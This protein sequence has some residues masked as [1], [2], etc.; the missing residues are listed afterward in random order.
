MPPSTPANRPVAGRQRRVFA[1]VACAPP[2]DMQSRRKLLND[3]M[4]GDRR[5]L[6]AYVTAGSDEFD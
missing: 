3:I 5:M 6:T 1:L 4:S 2:A